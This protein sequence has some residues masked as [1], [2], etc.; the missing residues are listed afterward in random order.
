M[1]LGWDF[2]SWQAAFTCGRSLFWKQV[3]YYLGL[4]I[5]LFFGYYKMVLCKWDEF[6]NLRAFVLERKKID[7][8]LLLLLLATW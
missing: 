5:E 8:S 7:E 1:R 2:E 4:K 6:F 3:K